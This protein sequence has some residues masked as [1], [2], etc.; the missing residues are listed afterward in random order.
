MSSPSNLRLSQHAAVAPKESNGSCQSGKNKSPG[1][2]T[3]AFDED[4]DWE[5]TIREALAF[6]R[7][8]SRPAVARPRGGQVVG[9]SPTTYSP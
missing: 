9:G 2:S 1:V 4:R 5:E 6:R 3:G 8:Q 7:R